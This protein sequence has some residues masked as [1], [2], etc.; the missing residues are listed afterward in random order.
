MKQLF[1]VQCELTH[2][3]HKSVE[4]S[5]IPEKYAVK[6]RIIKI[7]DRVKNEW[8]DNWQVTELYDKLPASVVESF[9]RDYLKQR[10]QSDV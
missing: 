5:W 3:D 9:E 2:L 10:E 7:F 8:S 4:I 6:G 1:Y